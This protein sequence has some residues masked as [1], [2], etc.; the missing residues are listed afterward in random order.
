MRLS[1]RA[2]L[3][4]LGAA[5]AGAG[6]PAAAQVRDNL[7]RQVTV[8][9]R[10]LA[11]FEPRK[12]ERTRFGELVFRSGMVL[13]CDHPRFGGF[14]SLWRSPNG[15]DFVALADIAYWLTGR[16][17]SEKGRL[18]GIDDAVLAPALDANGRP[19]RW[20]RYYDTE[21]L[22]MA[23]GYAYVGLERVNAV[24]R[25]P[26]G[27]DGVLARG[28][29]LP[30]PSEVKSLPNN[31]GLE[32]IGIVPD[33]MPLAGSLVAVAERSGGDDEPTLGFILSGRQQGTFKVRRHDDYDITDLAFLPGGDMLLLERWYSPFR[34][35]GMRIR[36]IRGS[37]I[38]PGALLDGAYLIEA[39]LGQEIDNM[40]GLSVHQEQG[41]TILTVISDDNFSFLQRTVLLE[42]ELA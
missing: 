26:F 41:R 30:V 37:D 40:E 34:G 7:V 25:F 21:S 16:L 22:A 1:R 23:D 19:M 31:R 2:A 36:R 20:S 5:A 27:R 24:M 15:R 11:S 39:D 28:Q 35:V 29:L 13:R 9:T 42:F 3:L 4:G 17:R 10:P 32:A 6:G 38:R 18:T 12:P 8:T 33:G 14:S